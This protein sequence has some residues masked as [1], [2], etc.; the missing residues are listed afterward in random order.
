MIMLNFVEKLRT[1]TGSRRGLSLVELMIAASVLAIGLVGIGRCF[2]SITYATSTALSY[3]E[4]L[5]YLQEKINIITEE[6]VYYGEG[7][8]P[9]QSYAEVEIGSRAAN[10][11]ITADLIEDSESIMEV[12]I[13]VYWH[14][15]GRKKNKTISTY[16]P[17]RKEGSF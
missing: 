10:V 6:A 9:G 11:T 17:A 1:Q 7:I 15:G 5:Q 8:S 13:E 16:L 3:I 2:L 4:A 14:E 12:A